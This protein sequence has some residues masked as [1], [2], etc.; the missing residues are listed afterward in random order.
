MDDSKML[1]SVLNQL[2]QTARQTAKQIAKLP[3]EMAVDLG[4]QIKGVPLRSEVGR[5]KQEGKQWDSDEER[6]K[7]LRGLYGVS[8]KSLPAGQNSSAEQN[9]SE[10]KPEKK[11]TTSANPL[12]KSKEEPSEFQQEIA[13]K[14]P[15]EQRKLLELRNQL[16]KENYYNPLTSPPKQQEERPAEK[17]EKEKQREMQELEQEKAEKPPPLAVQRERN[18]AEMFRGASG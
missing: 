6:V 16:H 3:E 1:G 5:P 7:F 13:D 14:T 12:V 4:E 15:E 9:P 17:V 18:K 11:A 8:E 10:K 2:G